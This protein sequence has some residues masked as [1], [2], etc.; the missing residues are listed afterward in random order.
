MAAR[1][2]TRRKN[3]RL[4][5]AFGERVRLLRKEKRWTLEELAD[6]AGLHVTYL[7]G[8]ERGRR[9]PTLNVIAQ[10]ARALEV[11]LSTLFKEMRPE[12]IR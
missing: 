10:L 5:R 4:C 12:Q 6:R 2:P 9:N 1:R 11:T 3:P 8:L 7:S